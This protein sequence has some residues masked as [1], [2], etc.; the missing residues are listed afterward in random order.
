[1]ARVWIVSLPAYLVSQLPPS[2]YH[3]PAQVELDRRIELAQLMNQWDQAA[4]ALPQRSSLNLLVDTEY[5]SFSRLG[6]SNMVDQSGEFYNVQI[7]NIKK[8]SNMCCMITEES[9][10]LLNLRFLCI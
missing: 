1:M 7:L 10:H 4:R 3:E 5:H 8:Q 2:V 9:I 6:K